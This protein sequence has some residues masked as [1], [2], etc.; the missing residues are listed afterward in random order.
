MLS[1]QN[2]SEAIVKIV[3]FGCAHL[4]DEDGADKESLSFNPKSTMAPGLSA[5]SQ[6]K[7]TG[8][9]PAYCPPEILKSVRDKPDKTLPSK[10]SSSYDMWSLGCVLYTMLLGKFDLNHLYCKKKRRSFTME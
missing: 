10:L 2:Q 6:T 8:M 4:N 1:S 9:T 5:R 3:D 7:G